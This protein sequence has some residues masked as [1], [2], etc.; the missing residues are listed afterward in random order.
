M[1]N[2]DYITNDSPLVESTLQTNYLNIIDDFNKT[3]YKI[4]IA[5]LVSYKSDSTHQRGLYDSNDNLIGTLG[6]MEFLDISKLIKFNYKREDPEVCKENVILVASLESSDIVYK[7][8]E[9]RPNYGNYDINF[10][11]HFEKESEV[12]FYYDNNKWCWQKST[13]EV[14]HRL[15]DF[16][17]V[18]QTGIYF[19]EPI[20]NLQK[21]CLKY[22]TL[23]DDNEAGY[24]YIE[25]IITANSNVLTLNEKLTYNYENIEEPLDLEPYINHYNMSNIKNSA[26]YFE[27]K[28]KNDINY[29]M[30]YSLDY[31]YYVNEKLAYRIKIYEE[32]ELIIETLEYIRPMGFNTSTI[33]LT[34]GDNTFFN[35]FGI[36]F[37]DTK[38]F[39]HLKLKKDDNAND[40]NTT[41]DEAEDSEDVKEN[42]KI[43]L[44]TSP[45]INSIIK[46]DFHYNCEN[47]AFVIKKSTETTFIIFSKYY[48]NSSNQFLIYEYNTIINK[49]S[50]ND[51]NLVYSTDLLEDEINDPKF[52][53]YTQFDIK[54][55]GDYFYGT[56]I[57]NSFENNVLFFE[58]DKDNYDTNIF[59]MNIPD[60]KIININSE[61]II[62]DG[63]LTDFYS[64]IYESK[65]STLIKSEIMF[66]PYND[67][68]LYFPFT[69]LRD[70]LFIKNIKDETNFGATTINQRLDN[71]TKS[72]LLSISEK[73]MKVGEFIYG[74]LKYPI[75]E[76]LYN[77]IDSFELIFLP[78]DLIELKSIQ[79]NPII[80]VTK[81]ADL[82]SYETNLIRPVQID[83]DI[84]EDI[85][86]GKTK[87]VPNGY[88]TNLY[89]F[90]EYYVTKGLSIYYNLK[91]NYTDYRTFDDSNLN[92]E[93]INIFTRDEN[94]EIANITYECIEDDPISITLENLIEI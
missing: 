30:I 61:R 15:I 16:D 55:F 3:E 28:D 45:T 63:V 64:L 72:K 46:N 17:S 67:E 47:S 2:T 52:S 36:D 12:S 38:S 56:L 78:F 32:D 86:R 82:D 5:N 27:C 35:I 84:S 80:P 87:D 51:L 66:K 77:S 70:G 11:K 68:E 23:N 43:F 7:E 73:P 79:I 9:N 54:S 57:L 92:K 90:N 20:S 13:L 33:N 83:Y 44:N 89:Y 1:S 4:N 49:N 65:I 76:D 19:K 71:D 40:N 62:V 88:I 8:D 18:T 53:N 24:G 34:D 81:F 74:E 50:A 42:E 14:N 69:L 26:S 41:E 94:K 60:D 29:T 37:K 85:T 91:L 10:K 93:I 6:Y 22:K 48:N 25:N 31:A 21:V 59:F 39:V 75:A 58:I